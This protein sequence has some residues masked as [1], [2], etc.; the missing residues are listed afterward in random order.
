MAREVFWNGKAF[1]LP[2][3]ASR[4]DSSGLNRVTLGGANVLAILCEC[5]GLI[6]PKTAK[7]VTNPSEALALIHPGSAEARIAARMAFDPA[8]G[9]PG[10]S[11]VLIIPVNPA[12][13]AS[14]VFDSKLKLTSHLFG[15]VAN[16]VKAKIEAGTT[17][18]TKKVTVGFQEN[19][20]AFDNLERKS[21]SIQYTG[22]GSASTM[23]I[24]Q[25][26]GKLTTACTGAAADD[27]DLA[28]AT[29]DTVQSLVDAINATGKYTVTVLTD[30]P[31]TEKTV[32]L[33]NV[34]AQDI[35]SAAYTAKSDLQAIVDHVNQFSA[36]V[37]AAK[38]TGA[39][40][41]PAN[42][43]WTYLAGGTNG[44]T[45]NN[46]WQEC[47]DLLKTLDAPLVVPLTSSASIWAMGDSHVQYMS[48]M[49]GKLERRQFVGGALK[50]WVAEA[51]RT[52]NVATLLAEAKALN[53]DRTYHAGL[54]V[55]LYDEVGNAKLYPA[56]LTAVM[57]AG[58]AAGGSP[59]LP[60]TRKYL[61]CLGLEVELR[62]GEID[63]LIKGGL[64]V[65]IPDLVA[66]AG[67]VISRQMSTWLQDDDL[68]RIEFS[69]GRGADY[70]AREVRKRHELLIGQPGTA[71]LDATIINL[72]N[73]VL[74]AAKRAELIRDYDPAKT[75]LRV[76]GTERYI[77]Y[78]AQPILPV[79]WIFSTYHIEPV[80]FSIQLAA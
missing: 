77:D 20:E 53:T 52:T 69:V 80:A 68:F 74:D 50:S 49:E 29:Y 7:K 79:N 38:E 45:V 58:I 43:D 70:I 27:L 56:Y 37:S 72:T 60:L 30:R 54:G 59:V 17:V 48:G 42:A 31:K 8:K 26:T 24:D 75:Q 2:Q 22:L 5:V 32:D 28:F 14:K 63:D 33:D 16:Q 10:A 3:A 12:T 34:T 36:Y 64:M 21:F 73:A 35:L 78:S 13:A 66:G 47:F 25:A 19:T 55:K 23:T 11:E 57:Y 41:V 15:L 6:P 18:G 67:Y 51:S 44:T 46:D 9:L 65:P 71:G 39:A 40:A 1:R 61:N 4:I 62:R 76:E